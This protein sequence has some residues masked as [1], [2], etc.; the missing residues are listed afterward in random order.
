MKKKAESRGTSKK[1]F[2]VFKYTFIFFRLLLSLLMR[3]Y[4]SIVYILI[5]MGRRK[6]EIPFKDVKGLE[7]LID[8]GKTQEEIAAYYHVDQATISRRMNELKRTLK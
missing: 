1:R 6:K 5:N 3:N 4:L 7:T 2:L 8:E